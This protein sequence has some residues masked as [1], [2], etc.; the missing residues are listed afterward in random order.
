MIY[1][2]LQPYTVGAELKSGT[3]KIVTSVT[4]VVCYLMMRVQMPTLVFGVTAIV[5]CAAYSVIACAAVY[6]L[7]PKTF[8]LRL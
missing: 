3:Y 1:Y 7:A 5:F 8:K 6:R 2:L 4:Y